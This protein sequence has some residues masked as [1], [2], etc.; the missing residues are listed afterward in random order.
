MA[1]KDG[2]GGMSR[3][4]SSTNQGMGFGTGGIGHRGGARE[5]SSAPVHDSTGVETVYELPA[6]SLPYA[7]PELLHPPA[8]DAPYVPATPQDIWA[9]GVMLYALLAGRL[10]F[11]DSFEPRLTVK[12]LRGTSFSFSPVHAL[13][14]V[15]LGSG[16]SMPPSAPVRAVSAPYYL[17]SHMGIRSSSQSGRLH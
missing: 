2:A 15:C 8:P 3:Q 7:A 5:R 4:R 11:S 9:L 6:G 13:R 16:L 10:P 12:I 14:L 1:K 17:R